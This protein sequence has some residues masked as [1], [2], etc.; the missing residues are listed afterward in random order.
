MVW[1][2]WERGSKFGAGRKEGWVPDVREILCFDGVICRGGRATAED[3]GGLL[4]AVTDGVGAYCEFG[5]GRG[6]FTDDG[7]AAEADAVS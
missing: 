2:N 7:A 1:G 5:G 4:D 3:D 6:G